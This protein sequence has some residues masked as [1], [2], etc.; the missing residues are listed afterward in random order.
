MNDGVASYSNWSNFVCNLQK[1]DS[2][3]I[4]VSTKIIAFFKGDHHER[5]ETSRLALI[6]SKDKPLGFIVAG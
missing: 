1:N 2:V 3:R 5:A 4:R 6:S